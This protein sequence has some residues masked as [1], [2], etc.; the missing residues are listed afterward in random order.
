MLLNVKQKLR[1]QYAIR[2]DINITELHENNHQFLMRL[3]DWSMLW[4]VGSCQQA[5]NDS[6]T[7]VRCEVNERF[8]FTTELSMYLSFSDDTSDH[9]VIRI[10]HDA[11]LAELVYANEFEKQYR[12]LGGKANIDSQA[13]IRFSQN[14]FLNKWLFYLMGQGIQPQMWQPVQETTDE[15]N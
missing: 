14:C 13:A 3:L 2:H 5:L 12:Q 11:Q 4:T 15:A 6:E 10:Y 1:Q 9:L 7:M 8:K